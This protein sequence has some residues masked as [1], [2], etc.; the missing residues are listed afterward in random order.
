MSLSKQL[1]TFDFI[2]SRVSLPVC[3]ALGSAE[4]ACVSRNISLGSHYIY[5]PSTL[6]IQ[7][8]AVFAVCIML[9]YTKH[10]YTAVGRKEIAFF[11]YCYLWT[12]VVGV[13]LVSNIIPLSETLQKYLA[14][15]H[16]SLIAT[17]FWS[18][19]V[20]GFVGFQWSVEDGTRKSMW[21]IRLTSLFVF[22][23]Y[24]LVSVCTFFEV[25]GLSSEFP[26]VL[27][28][29]LVALMIVSGACYFFTQVALISS[30]GDCWP[31]G[32][33]LL[34]LI[35]AIWGCLFQM[36]FAIS[37]CD[38]SQHYIDSMFLSEMCVLFAVMMIY[39]YWDILTKEDLEI[40]L[41]CLQQQHTNH[42]DA[43][44]DTSKLHIV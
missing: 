28:W 7:L 14:A 5:E 36:V 4:P 21:F 26:I 32:A 30:L 13:F 41:P 11:L 24:F 35:S 31:L 6:A 43:T 40:S 18:L 8:L 37:I 3:I 27:Y 29:A 33:L 19:L 44:H 12:C 2:C 23:A 25:A 1:V 10:K 22:A 42:N 17:T 34:A 9:Y 39:K 38:A 20:N 15:V 16:L